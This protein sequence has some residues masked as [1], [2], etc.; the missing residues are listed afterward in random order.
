MS[1]EGFELGT[2]GIQVRRVTSSRDLLGEYRVTMWHIPAGK[3]E[4]IKQ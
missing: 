1:Q 4:I 3:S 2:F